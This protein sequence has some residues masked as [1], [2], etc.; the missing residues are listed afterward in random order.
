MFFTGKAPMSNEAIINTKQIL[1]NAPSRTATHY[2][3]KRHCY[4]SV[5]GDRTY[6]WCSSNE[7][8]IE[9]RKEL[10]QDELVLNFQTL[11][12]N[13]FSFVGL[14]TCSCCKSEQNSHVFIDLDG[15]ASMGCHTCGFSMNVWPAIW[16]GVKKGLRSYA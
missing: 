5:D 16:D 4:L 1:E 15:K 2:H 6:I 13:G 14:H 10:T 9:S 12:S 11:Q 8:W 3:L 7:S